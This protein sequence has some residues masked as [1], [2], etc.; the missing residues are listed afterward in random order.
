[1]WSIIEGTD[2]Q[3]I[4]FQ[5]FLFAGLALLAILSNIRFFCASLLPLSVG[6]I[7]ATINYKACQSCV[8]IHFTLYH[9]NQVW[10]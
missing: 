8:F 3:N 6:C 10:C 4:Y 7:C 2:I 5:M 9:W 1:M